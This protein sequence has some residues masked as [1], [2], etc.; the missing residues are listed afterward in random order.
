[1]PYLQRVQA[2]PNFDGLST[3]EIRYIQ[4]HFDPYA[5]EVIVNEQLIK[6]EQ[7]DEVEVAVAARTAGPSGWIV[8][9]L[10]MGGERYHIG[11]YYGQVEAVLTNVTLNTARYIVQMIAFY[12]PKR[13]AYQGPEDIAPLVEF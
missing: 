2:R 7:I 12:S 3:S 5:N 11:I 10:L 8:K 4:T 1:M 9:T 6:W 13:I